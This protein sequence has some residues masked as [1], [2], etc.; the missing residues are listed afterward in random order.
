[1]NVDFHVANY[2]KY[3]QELEKE[4]QELRQ[5]K[6]KLMERLEGNDTLTACPPLVKRFQEKLVEVFKARK[7]I[8]KSQVAS[9]GAKRELKW[10]VA[11]KEQTIRRVQKLTESMHVIGKHSRVVERMKRRIETEDA[12]LKASTRRL[13]D[14]EDAIQSLYSEAVSALRRS[15]SSPEVLDLSIKMHSA[16][17]SL[18]DTHMYLAF[19]KKMARAQERQ[20]VVNEKLISCLLQL[21]RKQHE[22]LLGKDLLNSDLRCRYE[23]CCYL[24]EERGVAWAQGHR[25]GSPAS[26]VINNMDTGV[27]EDEEMCISDIID[28]PVPRLHVNLFRSE[29][30]PSPN[31][32]SSEQSQPLPQRV[33]KP[34]FAVKPAARTCSGG[35]TEGPQRPSP[36]SSGYKMPSSQ[37]LGQQRPQ[38]PVSS[39]PTAP[40]VKGWSE[41]QTPSVNATTAANS[42]N[43]IRTCPEYNSSKR[44]SPS[45]HCNKNFLYCNPAA[46]PRVTSA[47]GQIQ[48]SCA[49]KSTTKQEL[50]KQPPSSGLTTSTGQPRSVDSSAAAAGEERSRTDSAS[51]ENLNDTFEVI[52]PALPNTPCIDNCGRSRVASAV[53]DYEKA[54]ADAAPL[55]QTRSSAAKSPQGSRRHRMRGGKDK[56]FL[57]Q[58]LIFGKEEVSKITQPLIDVSP[59]SRQKAQTMLGVNLPANVST[60]GTN[61]DTQVTDH[62][63]RPTRRRLSADFRSHACSKSKSEGTATS[64][65]QGSKQGVNENH[66]SLSPT[67]QSPSPVQH[68]QHGVI[69]RSRSL[70]MGLNSTH[71]HSDSHTGGENSAVAEHTSRRHQALCSNSNNMNVS[72]SPTS[73]HSSPKSYADA[74]RSPAPSSVDLPQ[75][76]SMPS[77]PLASHGSENPATSAM[78]TP[79]FSN[80]PYMTQVMNSLKKHGMPCL[81]EAFSASKAK[82]LEGTGRRREALKQLNTN[83]LAPAPV[84][85]SDSSAEKTPDPDVFGECS[86]G[87]Q[88]L[89]V[90]RV[91][92]NST[93]ERRHNRA[94]ASNPYLRD[95]V[96]NVKKHGFPSALDVLSKVNHKQSSDTVGSS[97]SQPSYMLPT[98]STSQRILRMEREKLMRIGARNQRQP[99]SIP[100][101]T[102]A[103]QLS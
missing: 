13:Q 14:Q 71:H 86:V 85:S 69:S 40:V 37:P 63:T 48:A 89:G 12:D 97:Q 45:L 11:R 21:V 95:R 19:V 1:M 35:N 81:T 67:S 58:K 74:V 96:H 98:I 5:A 24:V 22:V 91:L 62:D 92:K 53:K 77:T 87:K 10:K 66:A 90:G 30:S 28:F 55:S 57:P 8:R 31:G 101:T 25:E 83:T 18:H 61:T 33:V 52:K 59:S 27:T 75:S 49:V 32:K 34:T 84:S 79:D 80:N 16:E 15:K 76:T 102:M 42:E 50:E 65:S 29:S 56:S 88:T 23:K 64:P 82:R 26:P 46:V 99:Y 4:N 68:A 78:K 60:Q 72:T 41:I 44:E 7:E 103:G 47:E 9:D 3:V 39:L 93:K 2:K 43:V 54:A 38:G 94:L 20:A 17:A 70:Q 36:V 6:Q 100:K 73:S 51:N